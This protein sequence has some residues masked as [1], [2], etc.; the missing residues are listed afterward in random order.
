MLTGLM[1]ISKFPGNFHPVFTLVP[2]LPPNSSSMLQ[3]APETP[4]RPSVQTKRIRNSLND[5]AAVL[6]FANLYAMAFSSVLFYAMEH[7]SE[8]KRKIC[9]HLNLSQTT[10]AAQSR[11]EGE[12][13][14]VADFEI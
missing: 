5:S 6:L 13:E 12:S 3:T 14:S 2:F 8:M 7:F 9:S 4:A 1:I 10:A 11:R